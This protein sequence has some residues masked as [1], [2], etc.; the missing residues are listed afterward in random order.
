MAYGVIYRLHCVPSGRDYIG[1]TQQALRA[2]W[3]QHVY[4][5]HHRRSRGCVI[6]YRAIRKYGR[7]AFTHEVLATAGSRK[8]LNALEVNAIRKFKTI[9]GG[10]YNI[11]SGGQGGAH[12]KNV[13]RKMSRI[14]RA[15][16]TPKLRAIA[17]RKAAAVW[18]RPGYRKAMSKA[19]SMPWSHKRRAAGLPKLRGIS[20]SKTHR[21]RISTALINDLTG[22]RFGKWTIVRAASR[23]FGNQKSP[24]NPYGMR[25]MHWMCRCDCG[26]IRSV[27][28]SNLRAGLTH[29]C[30]DC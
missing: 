4:D 6:L 9:D 1:Q 23:T 25:R 13:R 27:C 20:F 3:Q 18:R 15:R 5:A 11:R 12:S 24:H 21:Q 19:L 16:W 30:G 28:G 29:G 10:G 8:E 17:S 14:Q 22:R 7:S 2:R 26:T